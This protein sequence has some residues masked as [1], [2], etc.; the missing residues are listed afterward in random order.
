[1]KIELPKSLDAKY[2]KIARVVEKYIDKNL[3]SQNLQKKTLKTIYKSGDPAS[4][5]YNHFAFEFAELYW[6][7]NYWKAVYLFEYEYSLK[8][9]LKNKL[10]VNSKPLRILSLGAGP[11]S[12]IVALMIW[13]SLHGNLLGTKVSITLMD[14]RSKQLA[15]A[16]NIINE[17]L[18]YLENV[19]FEFTYERAEIEN[20]RPGRN[21]A[22]IILMGHFLTANLITLPAILRKVKYAVAGDGDI[23]IMERE[24]DP[25]WRA[26]VEELFNLGL[27]PYSTGLS[28]DKFH[29]MLESLPDSIVDENITPHYVKTR[30]PANKY[31]LDLIS[32]YFQSWRFQ[33]TDLLGDIFVKNAVY[34]EKPGQEPAVC[35]ISGIRNYWKRHPML[36]D[37]INL[38]IRGIGYGDY[39]V[40]C[41][42]E[43]EFDTPKQHISIKGAL[44]FYIDNYFEKVKGLDAYFGTV[45]TGLN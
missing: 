5:N 31:Q 26:A 35:D 9:S 24:R 4:V 16:K 42:F 37:N 40:V 21:S 45:K 41:A 15:L 39:N 43:G 29:H 19:E 38:W 2:L 8:E 20:W 25:V 13:L 11:A 32:K 23:L 30:V 33:T 7:R 3:P 22:D 44:S 17:V 14:M 27:A 12:D 34:N 1:M 10:A 36:Q 6:L 18:P 28:D